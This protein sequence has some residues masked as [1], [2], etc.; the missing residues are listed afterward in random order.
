M[1]FDAIISSLMR[2]FHPF[3]NSHCVFVDEL[4]KFDSLYLSAKARSIKNEK[5]VLEEVD[6]KLVQLLEKYGLES[7]VDA[8]MKKYKWRNEE[9]NENT[10][11]SSEKF[12]DPKLQKLWHAAQNSRF[13]K[14]ALKTLH[15]EL[16]DHE[17]KMELYEQKVKLFN[18]FND[19]TL[20]ENPFEI[21]DKLNRELKVH[22]N[23]IMDSYDKLHQ[24]V[25]QASQKIFSSEKVENLWNLAMQNPNF[26]TSELES[27]RVEL[28]H[29]DKRLEKMKYHDEE[30]KLVKK[31]QEKLGKLNVF[32]ED[33]SSLE[34]ENKRLQ[35]KLR[36]LENY[37]ETKIVHTEL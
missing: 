4:D 29:F 27:L 11:L 15:K 13:S 2:F 5:L 10:I 30:L 28:D 37:L 25:A 23:D 19:N 26:T 36:K 22:H 7:A 17:Q 32:D 33:V 35:R 24:K 12:K 20:N 3:A 9:Q 8:Y 18:E 34:E 14:T 6:N 31:Q 21:S 16:K 1:E